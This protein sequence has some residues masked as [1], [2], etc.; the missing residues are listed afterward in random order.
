MNGGAPPPCSSCWPAARVAPLPPAPPGDL[1]AAARQRVAAVRTLR[2][3]FAAVARYPGGERHSDGVLLVRA[4]DDWRLRLVAPFGLTVL[5]A[6]HVDGRTTVTAP[7]GEGDRGAPAFTRLGPGD[8]LAFGSAGAWSPCHPAATAGDYWCGS[9]PTRW[10][11]VDPAS[12]T[13]AAEGV[14]ADGRTVVTR[15]Y[16]DYRTV[17]GVPLPFRIRIDYPLEPVF[18][19]ITV[20]RYELNPPL[21][22]AQFQPPAGAAS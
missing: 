4:P 7:L 11:S 2:A 20:G 19:D 13:I 5:D 9:P 22:D 21:R 15:R 14:L 10:V 16:A 1:L 18:V 12:A 3:Q 6:V 17:D 8:T